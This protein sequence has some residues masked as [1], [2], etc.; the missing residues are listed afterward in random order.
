LIQALKDLLNFTKATT[1]DIDAIDHLVTSFDN[2]KSEV[3]LV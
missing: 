3:I 1:N 2:V